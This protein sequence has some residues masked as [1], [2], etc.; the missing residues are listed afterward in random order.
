MPIFPFEDAKALLV[1]YTQELLKN[2]L[3]AAAETIINLHI[4][5]QNFAMPLHVDYN[6]LR[7]ALLTHGEEL[8]QFIVFENTRIIQ[9]ICRVM[10]R[11]HLNR[12]GI[13]YV[14]RGE[15]NKTQARRVLGL[16]HSD[17]NPELLVGWNA[18]LNAWIKFGKESIDK[19]D[20]L[21]NTVDIESL[22]NLS[23]IDPQQLGNATHIQGVHNNWAKIVLGVYSGLNYLSCTYGL[24]ADRIWQRI[25]AASQSSQGVRQLMNEAALNVN[26]YGKALAS[27][28]FADLGG[29]QFIKADVHVKSAIAAFLKID[30]QKVT[31]NLAFDMLHETADRYDVSPRAIDKIMYLGGSANL[32][33]FGAPPT[34]KQ[35]QSQKTRFLC[36]LRHV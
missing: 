6:G 25:D 31:D 16:F 18:L 29:A 21:F 11:T 23:N 14:S 12:Q 28:F 2:D 4:D 15:N 30:A 1:G 5:S 27:S 26:Q 34:R 10:V 3:R 13:G 32:Y 33:F 22:T 19:G 35:Q 36:D 8:R 20:A 7:N 17:F 9:G 24:D